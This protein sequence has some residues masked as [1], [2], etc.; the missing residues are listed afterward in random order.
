M[1][2]FGFIGPGIRPMGMYNNSLL[3]IFNSHRTESGGSRG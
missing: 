2:Y 3:L 1:M